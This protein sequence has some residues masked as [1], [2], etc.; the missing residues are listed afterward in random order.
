M[1]APYSSNSTA[2][3]I[4]TSRLSNTLLR[5]IMSTNFWGSCRLLLITNNSWTSRRRL[6]PPERQWLWPSYH[7]SP[8]QTRIPRTTKRLMVPTKTNGL[9]AI[10]ANHT[11]DIFDHHPSDL[12]LNFIK[13]SQ[14]FTTPPPPPADAAT[15]AASLPTSSP[16][17]EEE[18][19]QPDQFATFKDHASNSGSGYVGTLVQPMPHHSPHQVPFSLARNPPRSCKS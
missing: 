12:D 8:P 19:M 18:D 6:S 9:R 17:P 16:L 11:W 2:I 15:A 13:D 4:R 5:T 7:Q 10:V 3:A 1:K 14:N